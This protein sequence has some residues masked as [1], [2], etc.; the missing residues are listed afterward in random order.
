MLG[1]LLLR[2]L[3]KQVIE[4]MNGCFSPLK[5]WTFGDEFGEETAPAGLGIQENEERTGGRHIDVPA[6]MRSLSEP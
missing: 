3:I 4:E 2:L 5:P 1:L 6:A